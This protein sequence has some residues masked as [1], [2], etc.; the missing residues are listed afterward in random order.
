M[1]GHQELYKLQ[2]EEPWG[3]PD[4]EETRAELDDAQKA[5]LR[6]LLQ[7]YS[8]KFSGPGIRFQPR[9]LV[10]GGNICFMNSILQVSKVHKQ[11]SSF[12]G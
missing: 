12:P 10:N 1:P 6:D 8:S 4:P 9:G 5:E 3:E 11:S 2:E 7:E